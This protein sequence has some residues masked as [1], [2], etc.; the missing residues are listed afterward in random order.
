M[1]CRQNNEYR[2]LLVRSLEGLWG[3]PKGHMEKGESEQETALREVKEETG[4]D[5]TLV[6]GFVRRDEYVI[7]RNTSKKVCYFLAEF[8]GGTPVPQESEISEIAVLSYD[9]A[10][11][12]LRYS[13]ARRILTE[14]KDYLLS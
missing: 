7:K 4:L 2:F 5:V 13:S 12:A 3:F 10:M 1:F 8:T 9:D 11:K 14:G 6:G